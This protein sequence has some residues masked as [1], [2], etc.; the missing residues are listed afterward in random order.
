V[1]RSELLLWLFGAVGLTGATIAV[2]I[3]VFLEAGIKASISHAFD[4]HL[5]KY[6]SRLKLSEALFQRQF[7]ALSD[8]YTLA[9]SIEP[10]RTDPAM[11][12]G[13][14][15][16][17]IAGEFSTLEKRVE[18]YLATHSAVLP[19]EVKEKLRNAELLCS[20]GKFEITETDKVSVEGNR[21][22]NDFFD[23]VHAAIEA[24][25]AHVD[26]QRET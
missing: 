3:K 2:V 13:E 11:D 10:T 19:R 16:D 22:A 24:L 6:K 25:Q 23:A 14:A 17:H 12:W 21:M 1:S 18:D 26:S 8:L 20:D 9:L 5:E 7:E 15:C 4:R